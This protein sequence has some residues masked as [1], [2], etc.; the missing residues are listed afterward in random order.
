MTWTG[1]WGLA[2][3]G[4]L[5]CPVG[6][7]QTANIT[8]GASRGIAAMESQQPAHDGSRILVDGRMMVEVMEP[9]N[10]LRYNRGARFTPVAAVLGARLGGHDFLYNPVVHDAI[11]DH[12]GLAT[13]FDL[14]APG[15]PDAW[16]P[17]GYLEARVGEGYLKVGV[18][19]LCKQADRYSLFQH[20]KLL[21]PAT[22]TVVWH[23]DTADF[24]QVCPGTN[25]YAYDLRALVRVRGNEVAVEWALKNTGAK[26]FTT[27]SYSHNFFRLDDRDTGPG[28]AL[29]FPYDFQAAGLE[30]QQEQ[31]GREIRFMAAVPRWAN[32]VVPWPAAYAGP[33]QC[34]LRRRDAGMA[35]T[36]ETSRPGM[37]TA[38]H[39]R[40]GYVSPEQ[41]IELN[42]VP[43]GGATWT[44]TYR[45]ELDA[46]GP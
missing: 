2:C 7:C 13:E 20:P 30:P 32:M 36:C 4:M 6:G 26:A 39:A 45:L 16:M 31:A 28:C 17:P 11:D 42:L 37:R 1:R 3:L 12:A 9:G 41:F 23:P 14:V 46:A 15:D 8:G 24:H 19:V 38:I 43:G 35:I 40:P 10:P 33:N 21:T 25:G 44:R 29:S 5:W 18:G 34:T 22:T 27:R